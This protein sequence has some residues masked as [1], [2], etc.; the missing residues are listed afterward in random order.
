MPEVKVL[1]S[2]LQFKTMTKQQDIKPNKLLHNKPKLGLML[3]MLINNKK[4]MIQIL[5]SMSLSLAEPTK[6]QE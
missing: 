4:L 2:S 5:D 6:F 3:T 1:N